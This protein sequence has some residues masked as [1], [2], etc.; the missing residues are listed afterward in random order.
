MEANS[1]DSNRL[2]EFTH[3]AYSYQSHS[4]KGVRFNNQ[5]ADIYPLFLKFRP[6]KRPSGS[7]RTFEIKRVATPN[8]AGVTSAV[9]TGP[10]H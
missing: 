6:D 5:P 8:R 10:P 7:S 1:S 2:S 3:L 4:G 9:E